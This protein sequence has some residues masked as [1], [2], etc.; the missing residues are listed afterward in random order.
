MAIADLTGENPNVFYELALRHAW[1]KPVVQIIALGQ[2]LPF[3]IRDVNT[4]EYDVDDPNSWKDAQKR[5]IRYLREFR[6]GSARI[7]TPVS[8]VLNLS[9]SP[10]EIA[11]AVRW[12]RPTC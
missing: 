9:P 6:R 5:L 10:T 7:L 11:A 12:R 4:V 8:E 3:D 2:Q 1:Q